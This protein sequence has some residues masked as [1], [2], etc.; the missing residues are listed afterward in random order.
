MPKPLHKLNVINQPTSVA[1]RSQAAQ[2][3][4]APTMAKIGA[5][6]QTTKK[7]SVGSRRRR[8]LQLSTGMEADAQRM[9]N[10]ELSVCAKIALIRSVG[11]N[12]LFG[13][14]SDWKRC[15]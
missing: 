1:D 14:G 10:I 6:S 9:D 3:R 12:A 4:D 2:S 11:Y 15:M 8:V 5:R 13:G 7:C